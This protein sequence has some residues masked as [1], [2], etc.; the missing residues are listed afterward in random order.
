MYIFLQSTEHLP[1]ISKE[2]G[3]NIIIGTGFYVDASVSPDTKMLSVQEVQI[4]MYS[5]C[6]V[7]VIPLMRMCWA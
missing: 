6:V 2:T 3:V 1:R 5:V 7:I 4:Y